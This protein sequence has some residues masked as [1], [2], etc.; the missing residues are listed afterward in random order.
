MPDEIILL[1][2]ARNIVH[3]FGLTS[4]VLVEESSGWLD[5]QFNYSNMQ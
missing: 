1:V 2:Y 3:F 4:S 5:L